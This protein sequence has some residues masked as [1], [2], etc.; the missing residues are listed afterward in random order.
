MSMHTRKSDELLLMQ[1]VYDQGWD[2]PNLVLAA[3]RLKNCHKE[4]LQ[5]YAVPELEGAE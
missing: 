5:D 1:F 4:E 2:E 3:E